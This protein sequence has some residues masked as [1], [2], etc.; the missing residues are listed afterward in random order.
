MW[1]WHKWSQGGTVRTSNIKTDSDRKEG[2]KRDL[3][4]IFST[5]PPR[6]DTVLY[7]TPHPRYCLPMGPRW[8]S[9]SILIYDSRILLGSVSVTSGGKVNSGPTQTPLLVSHFFLSHSLLSISVYYTPAHVSEDAGHHGL[10]AGWTVR[11]WRCSRRRTGTRTGTTALSGRAISDRRLPLCGRGGN[12]WE[13]LH[14][15]QRGWLQ[16]PSDFF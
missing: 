1:N 14:W 3:Q 10:A 4:V 7:P 11:L 16:E 13:S 2:M 5:L 9:E 12:Y 15:L 8:G 6:W